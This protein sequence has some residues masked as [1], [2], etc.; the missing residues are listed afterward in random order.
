[1]IFIFK[2]HLSVVKGRKFLKVLF[3]L[4]SFKILEVLIK[5]YSGLTSMMTKKFPSE[6]FPPLGLQSNLLPFLLYPFLLGIYLLLRTQWSV[7]KCT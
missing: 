6:I 3:V 1:M 4:I 2:Q 5:Y 7:L